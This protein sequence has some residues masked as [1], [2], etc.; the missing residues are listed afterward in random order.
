MPPTSGAGLRVRLYLGWEARRGRP[1]GLGVYHVRQWDRRDDIH[2]PFPSRLEGDIV[3]QIR[4]FN[5]RYV[6]F[7][8]RNGDNLHA[9]F[10]SSASF[11]AQL[12]YYRSWR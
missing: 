4:T 9:R 1:L 8:L 12:G 11:L 5:N 10:A 7:N 6:A 3:T 2:K